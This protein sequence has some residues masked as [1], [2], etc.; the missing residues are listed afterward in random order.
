MRAEEE[1]ELREFKAFTQVEIPKEIP[2][3]ELKD[4]GK[5]RRKKR[6]KKSMV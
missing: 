4:N 2:K 5:I 6:R 3:K 1:K